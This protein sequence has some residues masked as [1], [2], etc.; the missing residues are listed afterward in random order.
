MDN[1]R[2]GVKSEG[3]GVLRVRVGVKSEWWVGSVRM[4]CGE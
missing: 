1:V 2:D 4:G 3:E